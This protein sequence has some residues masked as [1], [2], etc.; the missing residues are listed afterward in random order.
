MA[1]PNRPAD[2]C[3]SAAEELM[4]KTCLSK[5]ISALFSKMKGLTPSSLLPHNTAHRGYLA[6]LQRRQFRK[7]K[8]EHHARSCHCCCCAQPDWAGRERV[9]G[10]VPPG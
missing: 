10:R 5:W 8:G 3:A 4:L 6:R 1:E 2:S 9:V 7:P